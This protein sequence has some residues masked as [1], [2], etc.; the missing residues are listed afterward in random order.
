MMRTI[1]VDYTLD[2]RRLQAYHRAVMKGDNPQP[3]SV[4]DWDLLVVKYGETLPDSLN[5]AK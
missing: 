4:Q 3:V 2:A 1:K 5:P